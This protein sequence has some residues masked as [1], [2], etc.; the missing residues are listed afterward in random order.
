MSAEDAL[1][2][3]RSAIFIRS[4]WQQIHT[5]RNQISHL[6]TQN[7]LKHHTQHNA[8]VSFCDAQEES[9][10]LTKVD[11]KPIALVFGEF[12][13]PHSDRWPEIP[14]QTVSNITKACLG[15]IQ[16]QACSLADL[17]LHNCLSI[18]R[19]ALLHSWGHLHLLSLKAR[20]V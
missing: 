8:V 7:L 12:G 9:T 20:C 15:C 13:G 5:T 3:T 6:V 18:K 16:F 2:T 10:S 1:Q 14:C 4:N 11:D 17:F 19:Q